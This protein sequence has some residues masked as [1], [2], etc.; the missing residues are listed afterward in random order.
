MP[1]E[2]DHQLIRSIAEA[3][4]SQKAKPQEWYTPPEI[5]ALA[6]R[7]LGSID[8]D[9]CANTARSIPAGAHYVGAEGQN[10]LALPWFGNV[11]ANPPWQRLIDWSGK[12]IAE[13]DNFT[14]AIILIPGRTET[15]WYGQLSTA[16]VRCEPDK[17]IN[18][19][20][21]NSGGA[22]VKV[23]GIREASHLLYL[24]H[25]SDAFEA[26]ASKIGRIMISKG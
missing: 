25:K 7:V 13:R 21:R 8:L 19:L 16:S 5:I 24:G 2:V 17:R 4:S 3:E 6:L 14:Q 26:E 1:S 18:Y 20:R 12:I 22:L 9:P 11:F 15:R 23:N 10:G